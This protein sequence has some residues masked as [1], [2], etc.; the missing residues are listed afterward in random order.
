MSTLDQ[1][2]RRIVHALQI[3][4][5]A[6]FARIAGVLG[7][8]EQTVARRYQRMRTSG[9]I[10]VF[11]LPDP[12]R[13]PG[14]STWTLRIGCR[15]GTVGDIARA[16]ARRTDTG[17]VTIVAGG[18]ELTCQI[19]VYAGTAVHQDLLH[20][21][22]RATGVLSMSA[23]QTLH[24]FVGRGEFDW[25]GVDHPLE[26]S[27]VD[28][29]R[30]GASDVDN[31]ARVDA[32][33]AELLAVLARDGR[34]SWTALA[35]ATGWTQ[36]QVAARVTALT[37]SGAVR[38]DVDAAIT[39]LGFGTLANLWFTVAPAHLA[40]VGEHLADHTEIAYAA[41]VSGATNLMASAVCPDGEALY[42]YLTTKVAALGEIRSV[43][44]VPLQTRIKQAV[45][46]VE[47]GTLRDP[48][49]PGR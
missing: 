33:D 8:S 27:E 46:L 43:E 14:S 2:D 22:P 19:T 26:P 5:R 47:N 18:A 12:R 28:I 23:H 31:G 49:T 44:T 34:A 7:V 15:P 9:L 48:P 1:T 35:T 25:V 40:E 24:R 17:W 37:E 11:A 21:L 30:D 4:P 6:D 32:G 20:Q 39:L 13:I 41:A 45:C 10:R 36:R 29:L 3:A 38:F 42:R 16:L